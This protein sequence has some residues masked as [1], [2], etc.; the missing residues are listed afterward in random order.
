MFTNPIF[1]EAVAQA[2][3]Q[4]MSKEAT[5]CREATPPKPAMREELQLWMEEPVKATDDTVKELPA[6]GRNTNGGDTWN[7]N[8]AVPTRTSKPRLS[9]IGTGGGPEF[10]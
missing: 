10:R 5:A 7:P 4:A 3:Q 2:Y 9:T 6:R 1:R 8:T